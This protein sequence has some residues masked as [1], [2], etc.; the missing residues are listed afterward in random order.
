MVNELQKWVAKMVLWLCEKDMA[1]GVVVTKHVK[2]MVMVT[3]CIRSWI[4]ATSSFVTS[5]IE[6]LKTESKKIHQQ[7]TNLLTDFLP[8][9][10]KVY[11]IQVE[12]L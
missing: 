4:L 10:K 5:E 12:S 2:L 9:N 1:V 3:W 8:L 11:E 7:L 6:W